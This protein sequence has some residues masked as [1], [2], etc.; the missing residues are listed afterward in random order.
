MCVLAA[1]YLVKEIIPLRSNTDMYIA[2]FLMC[3][4]EINVFLY[5]N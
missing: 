4:S 3:S 5:V 2:L 1:Q